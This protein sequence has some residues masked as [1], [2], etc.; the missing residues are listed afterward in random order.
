M[1]RGK[2]HVEPQD[3]SIKAEK[4]IY[5]FKEHVIVDYFGNKETMEF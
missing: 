5:M 3:P 2:V 4:N 1:W